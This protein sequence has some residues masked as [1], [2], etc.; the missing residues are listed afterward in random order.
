MPAAGVP[1]RVAVPSP[2]PVKVT[3][4]GNAPCTDSAAAGKPLLVTVKLPAW[5]VANVVFAALV[6][7]GAC[8]TVSMKVW[9]A[10]ETSLPA[11]IVNRY[12]PALPAA[13]V[14]DS[15]AVPSPLSSNSTP[16]GRLP[17]TDSSGVGI[18][19]AMTVKLPGCPVLNVALAGLVI[20]G[21]SPRMNTHA[22]PATGGLLL[23]GTK[24]KGPKSLGPPNSAVRP[25]PDSA[26][27]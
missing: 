21:A 9:T 6:I 18:P 1:A 23:P 15:V 8:S 13:G 26:T 4:A 11:T 19:L 14:P 24:M 20:A 3:P 7:A 5:P 27:L 12:T 10:T 2:L 17:P 22:A 16:A 25:S